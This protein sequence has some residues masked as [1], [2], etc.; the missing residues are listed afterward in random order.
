MH[1]QRFYLVFSILLLAGC[2]ATEFSSKQAV[3]SSKSVFSPSADEYSGQVRQ[4][5]DAN[6]N[7]RSPASTDA[8][9]WLS[10][11][12][13]SLPK[14]PNYSNNIYGANAPDAGNGIQ[15]PGT[16]GDAGDNVKQDDNTNDEVD[17]RFLCSD[18]E[19]MSSTN[20]K[21]AVSQ[22][23][24]VSLMV[25]TTVCTDDINK[26]KPLVQK[27][28]ITI[29]DLQSLCPAA[30]PAAGKWSKLTLKIDGESYVSVDGEIEFLYALNKQII[31]ADQ[32]GDS[33]CDQ[34][35]SPLVIHMA[36]DVNNPKAI[37][38]SSQE[39]GIDFDLLGA[40]NNYESVRISWFTNEDYRMLALPDAEG[41]VRG[42]DQLFGNATTGPDG[43]DA[44]N[45][46]AALA[47]YDGTSADG[48]F[49]LAQPD[50]RIDRRDPIFSRLRLWLDRNRDGVSQPDELVSL[51]AAHIA[52]IDLDYSTDYAETDQYGNKTMMKSVVGYTNGALDL[53]F[54]LWFAY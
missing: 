6:G 15:S 39:D 47:K 43:Q 45:G 5:S 2:S 33:L 36:S 34:R 37:E 31:P 21:R 54:D 7:I 29:A 44:D 40:S 16:S 46:Y 38:L 22:N 18:N 3:L 53:I 8:S 13:G 1:P 49:R 24:P 11:L 32:A 10:G 35:S 4:G 27:K 14:A 28:S 41:K 51:K 20:Y 19:S 30:L 25:G 9:G 23:K 17:L 50:G 12:V 52:Y 26:I 42:I 48:H